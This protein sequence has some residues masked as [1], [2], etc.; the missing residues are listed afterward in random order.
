MDN[1]QIIALVALAPLLVSI[2][3]LIVSLRSS[4]IAHRARKFAEAVHQD[5]QRAAIFRS[6]TE[7]LSE[8]DR[9]HA[10]LGT[11]QFLIVENLLLFRQFPLLS[12][13]YPDETKRL[14]RNLDG[15]KHLQD[16]YDEQRK[17]SEQVGEGAD[18]TGQEA[19]LANIRRLTIHV[20][21]EISKEEHHME[22]LRQFLKQR[23]A[24]QCH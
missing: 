13:Q 6:R 16:A 23:Q 4:A 7:I 15:V 21:E 19:A 3:S 8:I 10:R 18:I 17:V 22:S 20:D 12:E 11:L 2:L 9:Q 1:P 14:A 5:N 24:Q